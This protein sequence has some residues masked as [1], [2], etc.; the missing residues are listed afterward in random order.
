MSIQIESRR[1]LDDVVREGVARVV[2]L[3]LPGTFALPSG[4]EV[5]AHAE[6][7]DRVLAANP[8]LFPTIRA[9]GVCAAAKDACTFEDVQGWAGDRLEDVIFA[10]NAAYYMSPRVHAALGYPGQTRRP[11]SQATPEELHSEELLAPVRQRGS[12]YIPTP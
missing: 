1:F 11:I 12:I 3:L 5:G 2:D 7:L 8:L 10:L 9:V 4:R 6:L